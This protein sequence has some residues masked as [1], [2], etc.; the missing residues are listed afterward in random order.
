MV[1]T[2]ILILYIRVGFYI[3]VSIRKTNGLFFAYCAICILH[4]Q[5]VNVFVRRKN[6]CRCM[7]MLDAI[8]CDRTREWIKLLSYTI[9]KDR[10]GGPLKAIK[11]LPAGNLLSVGQYLR[12][13][14]RLISTQIRHVFVNYLWRHS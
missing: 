5:K 3:S 2:F 4:I 9:E 12:G 10:Q 13:G 7:F 8:K 6:V 11:A 1:V 14:L